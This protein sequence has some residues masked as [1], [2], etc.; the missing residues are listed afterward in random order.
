MD[1]WLVDIHVCT[2]GT[3]P[4]VILKKTINTELLIGHTPPRDTELVAFEFRAFSTNT[5]PL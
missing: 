3:D 5:R 4:R 1:F 2:V